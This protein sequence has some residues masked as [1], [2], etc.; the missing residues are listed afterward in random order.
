MFT[1]GQAQADSLTLV[2]VFTLTATAGP[3]VWRYWVWATEGKTSPGLPLVCYVTFIISEG[4]LDL[5]RRYI[6]PASQLDPDGEERGEDPCGGVCGG[7]VLAPCLRS[8]GTGGTKDFLTTVGRDW[9]GRE[10]GGWCGGRGRG[11]SQHTTSSQ[12]YITIN[13]R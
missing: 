9:A 7:S 2:T 12:S 3:S 5:A 10:S 8:T 13:W 1:T 6:K 4:D 11:R